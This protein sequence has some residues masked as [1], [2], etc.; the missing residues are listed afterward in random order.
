MNT[1]ATKAARKIRNVRWIVK[2]Y[3]IGALIGSFI[4]IV[5]AAEKLGGHG[6]EAYATPFMIDGLAVI[7]MI[8]RGEEFSKRTNKI[9]FRVQCFMGSLSLAMNVY[10][11]A[12][13]FGV[14]FGIA[15]VGLFVFAEW[16]SDQIESREAEVTAE[17]E[18]IVA[19]AAA[20]LTN[21]AHPTSCTSAA[22]CASKTKRSK[23]IRKNT[24]TRKAQ[25]AA[26][27]SLVNG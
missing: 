18:A 20:F 1:N 10:A 21:C 17:A 25:A 23:T 9:G 4:H 2:L 14:L 13:L 7:G 8:M 26:L 3:F 24:R 22:Q 16:L 11:A 5:T 19:A 15:I 6:V 12:S 27:E